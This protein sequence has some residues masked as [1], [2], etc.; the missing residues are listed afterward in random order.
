M[1]ATTTS[2]TQSQRVGWPKLCGAVRCGGFWCMLARAECRP[3]WDA[4][5]TV[6]VRGCGGPPGGNCLSALFLPP[7]WPARL[8]AGRWTTS[9]TR[10][11][12][13]GHPP[14]AKAS[15]AS[16]LRAR[17]QVPARA[18]PGCRRRSPIC[19]SR[20]GPCTAKHSRSWRPARTRC[21]WIVGCGTP[22]RC[23]PPGSKSLLRRRW[24]CSARAPET[25]GI[26]CLTRYGEAYVYL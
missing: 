2:A 21:T 26:V 25:C 11:T 8:A 5:C 10:R 3:R 4:A 14:A 24:G 17:P 18:G 23:A 7:L 6:R 20:C 22:L 12:A 19:T 16:L 1:A 15:S 13:Q 9:F